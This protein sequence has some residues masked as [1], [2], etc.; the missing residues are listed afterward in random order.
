[1]S[2]VVFDDGVSAFGFLLDIVRMVID[3]FVE[4]GLGGCSSQSDCNAEDQSVGDFCSCWF[5]LN[6][7]SRIRVVPLSFSV[8]DLAGR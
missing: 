7:P 1:V 4:A 3:V 6:V 5:H 8:C 2:K